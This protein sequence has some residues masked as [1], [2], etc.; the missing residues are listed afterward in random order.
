M[1]SLISAET[2]KRNIDAAEE[3]LNKCFGM[4]MD[5]KHASDTLGDAIMNFQPLLADCLYDFNRK[6]FLPSRFPTQ[7]MPRRQNAANHFVHG[8]GSIPHPF[9]VFHSK[10]ADRTR[11]CRSIRILFFRYFF[12]FQACL[13]RRCSRVRRL[14]S[15]VCAASAA[16]WMACCI[17]SSCAQTGSPSPCRL[18]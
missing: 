5:I 7:T 18:R 10:Y 1:H 16:S 3:I 14:G 13:R 15:A 11:C 9:D 6:P 17:S 12:R 8:Q 2:A 4:L